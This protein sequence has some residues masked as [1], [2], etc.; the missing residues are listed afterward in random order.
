MSSLTL[1]TPRLVLIPPQ[2]E[3][4]AESAAMWADPEVSAGTG[5][6]PLPREQVWHRLLR[7][8]GHWSVLG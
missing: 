6:S 4:L 5:Q 7:H 3:D 2:P 8:V 1:T